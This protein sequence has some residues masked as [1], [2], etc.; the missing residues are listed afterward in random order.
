MRSFYYHDENLLFLLSSTHWRMQAML[1]QEF[2]T[3][4]FPVTPEQWLL[5]LNL[6]NSGPVHQNQL[7]KMQ[8]KDKAAIKRLLDHLEKGKLIERNVSKL[9]KRKKVVSLTES[10]SEMIRK[11]NDISKKTIKKACKGLT[12]VELNALKRL[13]R[14]IEGNRVS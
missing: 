10:G 1:K 8:F 2:K 7:A 6:M 11:L 14:K 9:D 13:I 5:M 3:R 12:E 4:G